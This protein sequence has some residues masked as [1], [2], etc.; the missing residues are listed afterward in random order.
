MPTVPHTTGKKASK[1]VTIPDD[2]EPLYMEDLK[3]PC[4]K[5]NLPDSGR[6]D[7]L[8]QRLKSVNIELNRS[9]DE[10]EQRPDGN[11][12]QSDLT[13]LNENQ[14][15]AL[16]TTL[17][18]QSVQTAIGDTISQTANKVLVVVISQTANEVLV[19]VKPL[20]SLPDTPEVVRN[21]HQEH[22]DN[23]SHN[24]LTLQLVQRNTQRSMKL[25]LQCWNHVN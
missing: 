17:I 8:C 25:I 4:R 1:Q 21:E 19:A 5:H 14:Q 2:L 12:K 15:A 23:P 16:N 24:L 11:N 13:W 20:L 9:K 18:H 7:M 10:D 6:I 3:S 22:P